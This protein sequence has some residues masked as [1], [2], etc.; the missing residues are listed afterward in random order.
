LLQ[1]LHNTRDMV[2]EYG[3]AEKDLMT[4]IDPSS[5]NT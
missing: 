5:Q 1:A 2:R 4:L 3:L